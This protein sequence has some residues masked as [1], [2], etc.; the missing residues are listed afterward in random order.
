MALPASLAAAEI[1]LAAAAPTR[2]RTFA[3]L[4]RARF[5]Y[6]KRPAHQGAPVAALNRLCRDGIVI[7]LDEPESSRFAAEAVAQNIHAIDMYA[8]FFKEGLDVALS[9]FVGQIAYEQLCHSHSPNC[10]GNLVPGSVIESRG[11]SKGKTEDSKLSSSCH[12]SR[13]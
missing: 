4:R 10:V 1:A 9:S 2:L 13:H 11:H 12:K 7:D 8:R 5:V 6:H 3:P